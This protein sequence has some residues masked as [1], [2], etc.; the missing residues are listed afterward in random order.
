MRIVNVWNSLTEDIVQAPSVNC[1]RERLDR[2][3]PSIRLCE[4]GSLEARVWIQPI[5]RQI[6]YTDMMIMMIWCQ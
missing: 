1:L 2:H 6:V 3:W 4:G 5:Y